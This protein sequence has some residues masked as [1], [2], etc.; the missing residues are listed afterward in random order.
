MK[1]AA[2]VSSDPVK[3]QIFIDVRG[4]LWRDLDFDVAGLCRT[5]AAQALVSAAV[6]SGNPEISVVLANDAFVGEL[7]KTWRNIDAPTNVLAFPCSEGDENATDGAE[8]LLGDV[9][10]AFETM[11]REVV[12]QHLSLQ[13]H[14]AHLMVHGVLHLLGYDHVDDDDAVI[15]ETME[16]EALSQLGIQNPYGPEG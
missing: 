11:R 6:T 13:D 7:N 9:I 15:M 10:I 2:A 8:Q 3:P 14:F 5:A 1:S 4:A 12:E 16:I